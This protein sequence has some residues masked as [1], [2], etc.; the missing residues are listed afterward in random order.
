MFSSFL[1]FVKIYSLSV[2]FVLIIVPP[3]NSFLNFL[4]PRICSRSKFF[5]KGKCVLKASNPDDRRSQSGYCIFIGTS[6]ISWCS[7]KQ[8][9]VSKS[10]TESK[11]RSLAATTSEIMWLQML[12]VELKIL[13][14]HPPILWCDNIW[15]TFLAVN[16]INHARTKYISI[17]YHFVKEQVAT[18]EDWSSI[19]FLQRS[20]GWYSY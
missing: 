10:S 15:A 4:L 2:I 3:S 14:H 13:Q 6:L 16:P 1:P 9:T 7:R 11:Y 5:F 12:L 17:D 18:K 8:P 20:V 19:Y